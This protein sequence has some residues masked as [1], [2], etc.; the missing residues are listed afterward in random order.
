MAV[1]ITTNQIFPDSH[2]LLM[3]PSIWIGDTV[4]T[5]EMTPHNIGMVNKHA[6][7]ESVSIIKG[8]KQVKKS[9]AIGDIP[10]MICNNQGVQIVKAM[11]KDLALVPD[12]TFN[13]FS[14][15]KQLKQGWKFSGS[16][17]VLVLTSPD[18]NNQI[19]FDIKISMPNGVLHAM[20][21]K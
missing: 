16:N 13:L 14:I 17:Y 6:A 21:I 15:S 20:C 4:A 18:G 5:M 3:Q 9:I 11:M 2:K 12:C 10:S 1:G 19:K 8:N 7:K